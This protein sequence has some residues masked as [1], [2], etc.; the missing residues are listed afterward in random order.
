MQIWYGYT[1]ITTF[2]VPQ[3]YGLLHCLLLHYSFLAGLAK[4]VEC[5]DGVRTPDLHNLPDLLWLLRDADL[6]LVD[7][8]GTPV[9]ATKYVRSLLT[10]SSNTQAGCSLLHHFPSL[11]CL[12]IPPPSSD[13]DVLSNIIFSRDKLTTAFNDN[14]ASAIQFIMSNVRGKQGHNSSVKVDGKL[15]ACLI[16]QCYKIFGGSHRSLPSLRMSW[17]AVM[18]TT[19]KK[20]AMAL[21]NDYESDMRCQLKGKLPIDDGVRGE[22]GET[23]MNIHFRVFYKKRLELI[24]DILQYRPCPLSGSPTALERDVISAF[25]DSVAEYDLSVPLSRVVGGRLLSFMEEN[26]KASED[27]CTS[28]YKDIYEKIVH[29]KIRSIVSSQFPDTIDGEMRR[30]ADEYHRQ[31]KGP[32]VSKVFKS[33]SIIASRMEAE[34]ELIPGPVEKLKA[35]GVDADRI[36]LRWKKPT[37]NPLATKFYDIMIKSRG[38]SW[39]VV[40]SRKGCSAL[41]TGLKS[42]TWY[43]LTVRARNDRYLGNKILFIR[44]RTLVSRTLQK[45]IGAGTFVASPIVYPSMVAYI[46]YGFIT[47]GM[48]SKSVSDVVGGAFV[49]AMLPAMVVVGLTPIAGQ[50]ACNDSYKNE[51]AN[52]K[53]DLKESNTHVVKWTGEGCSDD[54]VASGEALGSCDD[55]VDVPNDDE[56]IGSEEGLQDVEDSADESDHC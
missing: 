27:Y 29:I 1:C 31:A 6:L 2:F 45:I 3:S 39:E 12:T 34:V 53:G 38:R 24:N 55:L 22:T 15:L 50:L 9:T 21:L 42:S 26:M 14:L 20:K 18:E 49:L 28:L 30:F 7:K 47:R 8:D 13:E 43:C 40:A 46:G 25:E 44:V 36:K 10:R 41:V 52:K 35:V 32:A 4:M 48:E 56:E 51:I 11:H 37:I 17:S 33:R 54:S 23:L 16:R 19:M 5:S